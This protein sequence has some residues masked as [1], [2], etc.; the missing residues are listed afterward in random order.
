MAIVL[1]IGVVIA[2][3]AF[4][5]TPAQH[6]PAVV[7]GLLPAIAGWGATIAKNSLRAAGLGTPQNPLTPALIDQF[8]LSDTYIAG[9]F[10]LE[11][12][13]I[14]SCMIWAAITV[15]IIEK[16]FRQ[17]ALWTLGAA[18]LSWVGLMH[19][20]QWTS[21]D[22]VIHLGWGTGASWAVGY[23]LMA[24]LFGYAAWRSVPKE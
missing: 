12:G 7:I 16:D 11:Q 1:W 24:I 8:K 4:T 15:Y 2:A 3:Q 6:A 5:A 14:F 20:Y 18:A 13:F 22:T 19:S 9:A 23:L 10:A 17:A 21:A